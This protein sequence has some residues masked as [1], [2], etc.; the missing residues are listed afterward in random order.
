MMFISHDLAVVL[1][2]ADRV[3]VLHEGRV[4]EQGTSTQLLRTP[5]H[6]VT[7]SMLEASGAVLDP[8]GDATGNG[9]YAG[10]P[11]RVDQI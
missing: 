4:V 2:V 10:A 7:R 1:R 3:L 6:P 11:S 9:R 8:L 5:R